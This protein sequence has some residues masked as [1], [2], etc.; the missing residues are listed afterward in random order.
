[1]PR[2]VAKEVLNAPCVQNGAGRTGGTAP[3]CA[4]Q[5]CSCCLRSVCCHTG[6]CEST[7]LP[8]LTSLPCILLN[9]NTNSPCFQQTSFWTTSMAPLHGKLR[10]EGLSLRWVDGMHTGVHLLLNTV[11]AQFS[12][13][14]PLFKP[15]QLSMGQMQ[16]LP[17]NS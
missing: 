12:I 4:S 13:S 6:H 17:P 7:F 5:S 15:M 3:L 16:P 8:L 14:E 2:G 1:M 9:G 10:S 11:G